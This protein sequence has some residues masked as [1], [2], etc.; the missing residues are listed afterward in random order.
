MRHACV[1]AARACCAICATA[2]SL[3]TSLCGIGLLST[4]SAA[5]RTCT[6]KPVSRSRMQHCA[7]RADARQKPRA[8][9]RAARRVT[10]TWHTFLASATSRQMTVFLKLRWAEWALSAAQGASYTHA[11][12]PRVLPWP[13]AKDGEWATGDVAL[14]AVR[15]LRSSATQ[16]E[17]G[18]EAV[19]LAARAALRRTPRGVARCA[20]DE[21]ARRVALQ[22]S[23]H[24][25]F[26]C[27]RTG[28]GPGSPRTR[29]GTLSFP[30]HP[31]A[32]R[33][34]T[35]APWRSARRHASGRRT[36]RFGHSIRT[37]YARAVVRPPY[38]RRWHGPTRSRSPGVLISAHS[39]AAWPGQRCA[40]LRLR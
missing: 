40:S 34:A 4:P 25:P 6:G 22:A 2:Y 7:R 3:P 29:Q 26:A 17:L 15:F 35:G 28:S 9:A 23:R 11:D 36:L 1:T 12:A 38:Q 13:P 5:S 24:A 16:R 21:A 37:S 31:P 32:D 14:H 39:G 8:C 33:V 20:A 30:S 10:R 19:W 18:L 27:A